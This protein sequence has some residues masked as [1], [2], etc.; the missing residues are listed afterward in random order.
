MYILKYIE[1]R[2]DCLAWGKRVRVM[3]RFKSTELNIMIEV[4][5]DHH[6]PVTISELFFDVL[7]KGK[8]VCMYLL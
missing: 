1:Q 6:P 7:K 5:C 8:H 2:C 4:I 3:I